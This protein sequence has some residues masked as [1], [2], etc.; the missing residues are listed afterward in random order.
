MIP[1][2]V[3]KAWDRTCAKECKYIIGTGGLVLLLVEIKA[4]FS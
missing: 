1:I 4:T 2:S 3:R